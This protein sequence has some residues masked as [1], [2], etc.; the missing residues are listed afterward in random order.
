MKDNVEFIDHKVEQKE[1]RKGSIR[2]ILDGS[3]LNSEII[4]KQVPFII[5]VTFIAVLYIA[6]RYH[7]EKLIRQSITMQ[8]EVKELRAEAISTSAELMNLSKQSEVLKLITDKELG[9]K[10]AVEP[11]K[12]L[13]I[14]RN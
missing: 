5:F 4:I 12:K 9:L 10:E 14:E 7:S 2:E 11:P 1:I 3:V 13:I 6:N 8:E